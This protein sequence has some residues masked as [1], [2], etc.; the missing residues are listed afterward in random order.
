KRSPPFGFPS[1]TAASETLRA[2]DPLRSGRR[3]TQ[4]SPRFQPRVS[5]P[6][7]SGLTG[8]PVPA[9]AAGGIPEKEEDPGC[10]LIPLQGPTEAGGGVTFHPSERAEPEPFGL[11]AGLLLEVKRPARPRPAPSAAESP[12]SSIPLIHSFI[13]LIR[14]FLS[15]PR[16]DGGLFCALAAL[17][18]VAAELHG[19]RSCEEDG[20]SAGWT[21]RRNT[22]RETSTQC[23]ADWGKPTGSVCKISVV[24]E[25]DSGAYWCELGG[26]AAGPSTPLTVSAQH[27]G[28]RQ[29]PA[30]LNIQLTLNETSRSENMEAVQSRREEPR[31]EDLQVGEILK[32]HT[33]SHRKGAGCIWGKKLRLA[34]RLT[35]AK[36]EASAQYLL[37]VTSLLSGSTH[38]AALTVSP[39]S[40]QF[41]RED[42]VSLSCEED[43]SS[44]GWTVRRNTS[45]GTRTQCGADWGEL[46]GSVC[47]I[48]YLYPFDSGAYWCESGGG[49]AG[50]STP[51]TVSGHMTLRPVSRSDEGLYSCSIGGDRSPSSRVRVSENPPTTSAPPPGARTPPDWLLAVCVCS[52]V[53]LLVLV[54]VLVLLWRRCVQRKPEG[55][56]YIQELRFYFADNDDVFMSD[57]QQVGPDFLTYS[58]IRISRDSDPAVIY[59]VVRPDGLT[60][61]EITFKE[62]KNRKKNREAPAEPDVLYSSL[63]AS[64]PRR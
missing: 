21:V 18:G 52:V 42:S 19:Q 20:S 39:S 41:F 29:P 50:P 36:M 7:R 4:N 40:S 8:S 10:H 43:G 58:D 44:A 62:K 47:K 51:L 27:L 5:A 16:Q 61:G 34:Q 46:T 59:S 64:K 2:E 28:L 26:G 15:D 60:Y 23:G 55:E 57:E 54:L 48:R 3:T 13:P 56:T 25:K 30:A 37:L 12:Q 53:S 24:L 32:N 17:A 33:D 38:Q 9:N 11:P 14:T 31:R 45:R 22:S 63:K 6:E 35:D 1:C 49:A